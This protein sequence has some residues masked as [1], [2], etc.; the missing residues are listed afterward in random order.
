M[1]GV[2]STL[3]IMSERLL[4]SYM[5]CYRYFACVC[6]WKG[7]LWVIA[8]F[9]SI[10]NPDI[11]LTCLLK[12]QGKFDMTCGI[13]PVRVTAQSKPQ[14]VEFSW[15]GHKSVKSFFFFLY[16]GWFHKEGR[17]VFPE[18]VKP[19]AFIFSPHYHTHTGCSPGIWEKS[20]DPS[21]LGSNVED[22]SPLLFLFWWK[23]HITYS[24]CRLQ[25]LQYLF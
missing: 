12:W 9:S 14:R 20:P 15:C 21:I 22:Y 18:T 1:F 19:V 16:C 13:L 5:L 24:A 7:I 3:N 25:S 6:W 11:T 2:L 8:L 17:G 10:T 4:Y 23:S